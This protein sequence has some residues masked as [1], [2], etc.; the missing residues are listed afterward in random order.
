M[1]KA[2]SDSKSALRSGLPAPPLSCIL[3]GAL[4]TGNSDAG[5]R[6]SCMHAW[7]MVMRIASTIRGHPGPSGASFTIY[8]YDL[9]CFAPHICCFM[10]Y[11]KTKYCYLFKRVTS[12]SWDSG[13]SRTSLFKSCYHFP[14]TPVV[15]KTPAAPV[16]KAPK[17]TPPPRPK[18]SPPP[19]PP[20]P[21]RRGNDLFTSDPASGSSCI[22]LTLTSP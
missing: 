10:L 9:T 18:S 4:T 16:V 14:C 15:V 20:S 12:C 3:G 7:T 5:S 22:Y 19:L 8:L 6:Q 11:R 17:P 1:R 2:I 13:S 21:K